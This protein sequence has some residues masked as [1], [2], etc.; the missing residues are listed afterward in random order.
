MKSQHPFLA[1]L[2]AGGVFCSWPTGAIS[3]TTEAG[4]P[5]KFPDFLQQFVY[6]TVVV[7]AGLAYLAD[8]RGK[9]AENALATGTLIKTGSIVGTSEKGFADIRLGCG[10]SL[11][12]APK[13]RLKILAYAI[14]LQG[15]SIR[16]RHLNAFFPMKVLGNA[17]LLLSREGVA[18]IEERDGK[19][20]AQVQ[21]GK[22]RA[23]GM[24]GAAEPGQVVEASGQQAALSDKFPTL[25]RWD[26]AYSPGSPEEE[27]SEELLA[28]FDGMDTSVEEF[29]SE[30][31]APPPSAVQE[32]VPAAAI[33]P[34]A[35]KEFQG[36]GNSELA[37]DWMK[38][39]I[40][41]DESGK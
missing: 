29:A 25:F 19:F 11:R 10:S 35:P 4:S 5:G 36:N 8:E 9:L 22:L 30:E 33:T 1:I 15:G 18:D 28:A 41:V 3:Q 17:T 6:G 27:P 12:M 39:P 21:A 37:E 2:L 24:K 14:E 23:L 40:P 13:S 20:L 7:E 16:A 34:Q 31:P 38:Q 32:P 26:S